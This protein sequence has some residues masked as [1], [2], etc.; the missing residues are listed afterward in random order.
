M[1]RIMAATAVA[2]SVAGGAFAGGTWWAHRPGAAG[3]SAQAAHAPAVYTCP[4][5][6]DYRSHH[7]GSC[8]MCG[9]PLE[10]V[11]TGAP[12]TRDT[13][14][15]ALPPGAVQVSPE[16][17]QAIGV[18]VG[19]VTRLAGTRLLRTTGRVVPDENRTYPIVAA[20]SGWVRSVENVATGDAVKKD[21]VLAS[22]SAPE[23]QFEN[24]QQSYYT[25][26]EMLYR[27]AS[28]AHR[29]RTTRGARSTGSS[30][31]PTGCGTWASRTRSS[32]RWA[33]AATSCRTSAW[34][35]RWT[36]SC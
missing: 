6:P 9:M 23:S 25:G 29:S 7:P 16:R 18:R 35:R 8:P 5:H 14:A 20:V 12:T 19:V 30:G 24:A 22:I 33:S 17:Q 1:K 4:M 21:Q 11:A 32:G 13:A 34:S 10:A 2:V 27:D 28:V 36:A 31:S 15:R 3:A 26:L